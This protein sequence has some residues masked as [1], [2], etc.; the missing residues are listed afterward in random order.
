MTSLIGGSILGAS[1]IYAVQGRWEIAFY[2]LGIAIVF[3]IIENTVEV[4]KRGER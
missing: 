1:I 3:A 2:L 4:R